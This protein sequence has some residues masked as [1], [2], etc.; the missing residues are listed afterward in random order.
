MPEGGLNLSGL[1]V[2]PSPSDQSIYALIAKTQSRRIPE[3][4]IEDILNRF[5]MNDNILDTSWY[6]G[7]AKGVRGCYMGPLIMK[8]YVGHTGFHPKIYSG[9]SLR[10][11]LAT[12]AVFASRALKWRLLYCC[13]TADSDGWTPR[14]RYSPT[15]RPLD[16]DVRSKFGNGISALSR[17][18][19]AS[20]RIL[21]QDC[22]CADVK[23]WAYQA[24]CVQRW[25]H[26][27]C[28]AY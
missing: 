16:G 21:G 1:A 13:H 15:D 2:C 17:F 12:C 11:G 20:L 6:V 5:R 18:C 14:L 27:P 23:A 7:K 10:A 25:R 4:Q 28:R 19:R 3:K 9:H 8:R 22:H 26:V 24:N